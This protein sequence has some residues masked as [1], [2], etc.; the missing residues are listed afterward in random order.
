MLMN[1]MQNFFYA[2]TIFLFIML[3]N[4]VNDCI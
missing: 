1:K 3:T 4:T 2:I